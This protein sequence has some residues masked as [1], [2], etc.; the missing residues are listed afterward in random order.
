MNGRIVKN[1]YIPREK[2]AFDNSFVNEFT[3]RGRVVAVF[4][5]HILHRLN[6]AIDTTNSDDRIRVSEVTIRRIGR[7]IPCNRVNTNGTMEIGSFDMFLI[8]KLQTMRF[9]GFYLKDVLLPAKNVFRLE[10]VEWDVARCTSS[11]SSP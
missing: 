8:P 4:V 5:D 10:F 9:K 2:K 7:C 3:E 6:A 1:E 11:P